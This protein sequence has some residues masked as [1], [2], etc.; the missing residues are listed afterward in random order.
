MLKLR[1]LKDLPYWEELSPLNEFSE[2]NWYIILLGNLYNQTPA[3]RLVLNNYK[4]LHYRTKNIRYFVP[5][6]MNDDDDID[7]SIYRNA[8][9]QSNLRNAIGN[10]LDTVSI[11]DCSEH[12]SIDGFLDTVDW[13]ETNN[14]DYEYSEGLDM[15]LLP[16][17]RR[18]K[19]HTG[20]E[21][22]DFDHMLWFRM[23]DYMNQ[24]VNLISF[25]K[26][27]MD[28]VGEDMS[29]EETKTHLN[30]AVSSGPEEAP[31]IKVSIVKMPEQWKLP[32]GRR[33]KELWAI[34][35]NVNGESFNIKVGSKDQRMVYVC[36]LIRQKLGEHMYLHEFFRN[37]RGKYSKF[38]K[39][40]SEGW[41]REVY[42]LLFNN[43]ARDFNEWMRKVEDTANRGRCINQGK[44]QI[45]AYIKDRLK[46]F[47]L[48]VSEMPI[49]DK[50]EDEHQDSYYTT[51]LQPEDI[52]IPEEFLSIPLTVR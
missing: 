9:T 22:Y 44:S 13:L 31:K 27:A 38:T 41:L 47:E 1:S 11:D 7:L 15:I 2:H 3:M 8:I 24:G 50:M 16:Y 28:V 14:S 52:D 32:E 4:Y 25:M 20:N 33:T 26:K 39:K 17:T 5:G 30:I 37:S 40:G 35:I 51:Y 10:V 46:A 36:T 6:F 43:P 19:T 49:I 21:V 45:N 12:F 29:Y 42:N 18:E 48:D 23:D 34:K